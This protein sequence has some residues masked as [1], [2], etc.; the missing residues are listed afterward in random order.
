MAYRSLDFPR[1]ARF[2]FLAAGLERQCQTFSPNSY[3]L[4]VAA[5]Q[6]CE[7]EMSHADQN[8]SE[9]YSCVEEML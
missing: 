1:R 2:G 4:Q 5:I 7:V 9:M 3:V 6:S 8:L